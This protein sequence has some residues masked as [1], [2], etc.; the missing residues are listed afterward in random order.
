MTLQLR[1]ALQAGRDTCGGQAR[2]VTAGLPAGGPLRGVGWG[3][4]PGPAG[5]PCAGPQHP[6]PGPR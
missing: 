6:G 3:A 4:H 1:R 2:K 5:A